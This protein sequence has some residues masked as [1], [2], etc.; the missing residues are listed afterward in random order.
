MN[1]CDENGCT[2][3]FAGAP[4]VAERDPDVAVLYVTD[5]ICSACWAME[6]GWRKLLFHFG[7]RLAVRHVY[8]GLLPSWD[9]FTDP[10]AGIF[11]P[12]D[13]A[14]H[15]A[16]VA[17]RTGQP[18]DPGVWRTDPPASSFPPSQAAHAVRML[19]PAAE[20]RFLRRIREAVF[21]QARNISRPE[22][23]VD[24]ARDAGVDADAFSVLLRANAG[25]AAFRNDLAEVRRLPVRGFPTVIVGA[26]NGEDVVLHGTS[27]FRRL[28][29]AVATAGVATPD[30]RPPTVAEALT[31]YATGTTR[32]FA[33]LLEV[34][35]RRAEE[36]LTAAGA[37]RHTVAGSAIWSTRQAGA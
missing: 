24:C 5:P 31:A 4:A 3:P 11:G 33:E 29:A 2:I 15:W 27:S 16:E 14:S 1:A 36:M 19:D 12:A 13:V 35:D 28:L 20:E 9:G 26:H 25:Q 8:G 7:S 32:E 23:L 18:I 6:P 37:E 21:L 17:A 34:G 22:V 10:G 30:I